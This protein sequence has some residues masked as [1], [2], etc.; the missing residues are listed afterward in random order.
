LNGTGVQRAWHANGQL[1]VEVSTIRG[2]FCG[3]NR[4]WLRDGTLLSERFYLH[5]RIVSPE[6]YF[7]AAATDKTLP[8]YQGN[9][10]KL[11]PRNDATEARIYRLFVASL[12]EKPNRKEARA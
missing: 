12:L 9:P 11:P 4:I 8:K 2:E 3:R 5:G 7:K 10:A 6:E 1:Q